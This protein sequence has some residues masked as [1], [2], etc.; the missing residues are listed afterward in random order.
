MRHRLLNSLCVGLFASALLFQ[1]GALYTSR[2][3]GNPSSKAPTVYTTND[4]NLST[5][6]LLAEAAA[7]NGLSR[8]M[9]DPLV[10]EVAVYGP[11][12]IAVLVG[13]ARFVQN[14]LAN[15]PRP[16]DISLYSTAIAYLTKR[17]N[18][19]RLVY[20]AYRPIPPED[21]HRLSGI[22]YAALVTLYNAWHPGWRYY[23]EPIDPS[24]WKEVSP[25]ES[26]R[27]DREFEERARRKKAERD[28]L[29]RRLRL[30]P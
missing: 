21:A 30:V 26:E 27:L 7:L 15:S 11:Y 1:T 28:E 5:D 25:E 8:I 18:R 29:R 4:P 3:F 20:F 23:F 12:A 16:Q 13:D 22:P 14:P 10:E 17:E 24:E 9:P 19:W 6:L 2:V